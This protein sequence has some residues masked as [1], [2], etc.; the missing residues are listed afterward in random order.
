MELFVDDLVECHGDVRVRAM[1]V[2]CSKL[3]F[4]LA[5]CS[6]IYCDTLSVSQYDSKVRS[7]STSDLFG[8]SLV[9]SLNNLF[10][11]NLETCF[12]LSCKGAQHD[13]RLSSR[14]LC[15]ASLSLMLF[16]NGRP[17]YIEGMYYCEMYV[18]ML[19]RK[20]RKAPPRG[21]SEKYYG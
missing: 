11:M 15:C 16:E 19:M 14:W 5:S 17:V 6:S 21:E 7:G 10:Y 1:M 12:V 3:G 9:Q 20:T 8:V 13:Q 18:Q 2:L 4:G